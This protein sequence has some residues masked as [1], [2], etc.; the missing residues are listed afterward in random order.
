MDITN[1]VICI[2]DDESPNDLSILNYCSI[3][4]T[5][6]NFKH[7]CS[8]YN[9]E[10]STC[11]MP[12]C[13]ILSR[14]T[15]DFTPHYRQH[16]G[17]PA[18]VVLCHRCFKENKKSERDENGHHTNC[19]TTNLFKCYTCNV[20][21]NNMAEF[22][23]HKLKTHN[24]RLINSSGNYLCFYCEKSSQNLMDINEHIKHCL[25]NQTETVSE[26][27]TILKEETEK[28]I[29]ISKNYTK[30]VN[31]PI[32]EEI[33]PRSSTHLLFTCLKPSCNIIFQNFAIFKSH[34]REHF[35]IGNDLMCWQCCSPFSNLNL[36]RAHQVKGYCRTPG[37]FKCFECSEKYND[38][39]SLSIHKFIIHDGELMLSKKNKKN[40]KC[41]NCKNEIDILNLKSHLIKCQFKKDKKIIK[42]SNNIITSKPKLIKNVIR[43][44][45]FKCEF[46]CKVCLTAAAL[47]SHIKIHSNVPRKRM[48]RKQSKLINYGENEI[49]TSLNNSQHNE[50][51]ESDNLSVADTNNLI[52]IDEDDNTLPSTS[53]INE[54]IKSNNC[55]VTD[56]NDMEID[57]EDNT[58]PSTSQSNES[59]NCCVADTN[60]IEIDEEDNTLPSTSKN[61]KSIKSENCNLGNTSIIKETD[62]EVNTLPSASLNNETVQ[63]DDCN[64][65]DS[66]IVKETDEQINTLQSTSKINGSIKFDDCDLTNSSVPKEICTL[67]ST[68]QSSG[69]IKSDCDISNI[70]N[71]KEINLR[72][73]T[74]VNNEV[75]HE[76][77]TC[78]DELFSCSKCNKKFSSQR[79]LS[80]HQSFH[81]KVNIFPK[82][83]IRNYYCT[84]CKEYFT[85]SGFGDHWRLTHGKRL[86]CIKFKR[87]SCSKCQSKFIYKMALLMHKEHKH[88]DDK[89]S[90][91]L[92]MLPL[93]ITSTVTTNKT[94]LGDSFTFPVLSEFQSYPKKKLQ[95]SVE[96]DQKNCDEKPNALL[97]VEQAE[98]DNNI[99]QNNEVNVWINNGE[100]DDNT[101]NA[102]K[103]II[104][105]TNQVKET[106][107]VATNQLC[108]EHLISTLNTIV[109]ETNEENPF[110]KKCE[111]FVMEEKVDV[112]EKNIPSVAEENQN[113]ISQIEVKKQNENTTEV[114]NINKTN[115]V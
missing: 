28:N 2:S 77:S 31:T 110:T 13:N 85:S 103:N 81:S 27:N 70:S 56:T 91:S 87:Y 92:N 82:N 61:N 71:T 1:E 3:C 89:I 4:K 74:S 65:A 108:N 115:N 83:Q 50:S 24:G 100:Y 111:T 30:K 102:H 106:D 44:A 67:P 46:C 88:S 58:L 19:N 69:P 86:S 20:N 11:L 8:K 16:I 114:L 78:V 113:C 17:I 62:R 66:S 12:N 55:C 96:I 60:D 26:C 10:F 32:K 18:G 5:K 15:R 99:K 63:S 72:S 107:R 98:L 40:I 80:V 112:N 35:N 34:H 22:A 47:S 42:P 23:F 95:S 109:N 59:D 105:T 73:S 21:F 39:Q 90:P 7:D 37:M 43:C 54:S 41:P 14:S 75:N 94:A 9:K 93:K 6:K 52:E 36:L 64:I 45:P 51:I 53:Q 57:E 25:E 48:I 84:K 101:D 68:S 76:I 38:L 79:G 104:Q 49:N 29:L 97:Q 33:L